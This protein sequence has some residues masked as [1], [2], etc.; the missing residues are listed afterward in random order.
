MKKRGFT[1]IELL[2]VIAIIAILAAILFPV[3]AQAREKAR[4]V[5]CVSNQKQ[6]GTALIMYAQDYDERFPSD[7]VYPNPP[8]SQRWGRYFW[9]FMIQPYIKGYPSNWTSA[10]GNVYVCPSQPP[11]P[12]HITGRRAAL[13]LPP[14]S[15]FAAQWG[16]TLNPNPPA[17]ASTPVFSYFANYALNELVAD[18][19][20]MLSGW[21]FPAQAFLFVESRSTEIEGDELYNLYGRTVNCDWTDEEAP[22]TNGGHSGGLNFAYIDGHVKF[23][24]LSYTGTPCNPVNWTFPPGTPG[25]EAPPYSAGLFNNWTPS[26]Q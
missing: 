18:T 24:R 25:G 9:M 20:P 26:G 7:L 16:L 8:S 4:Q 22:A 13:L 14:V 21:Q 10:R 19:S 15:D 6:I 23:S 5:S 3:F 2:L 12:V 17:G 1:L 11:T